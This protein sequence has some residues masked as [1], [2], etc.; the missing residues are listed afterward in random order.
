M[1]LIQACRGEEKQQGE[2]VDEADDDNAKT[3]ELD[4]DESDELIKVPRDAD[5][6]IAYSTT[7][8]WC[9]NTKIH[10]EIIVISPHL[11]LFY[12]FTKFEVCSKPAYSHIGF[13]V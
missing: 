9:V 4:Q 13:L 12:F 8:G 5:T 11:L 1:F 3:A 6:L 2:T 7:P 10:G